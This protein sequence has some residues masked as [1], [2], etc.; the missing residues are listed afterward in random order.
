MVHPSPNALHLASSSSSSVSLGFL[1]TPIPPKLNLENRT[2]T[3][4]CLIHSRPL[5]QPNSGSPPIGHSSPIALHILDSG[6]GGGGG[7]VELATLVS[8]A[9]LLSLVS[10]LSLLSLLSLSLTEFSLESTGYPGGIGPSIELKSEPD[11]S[12]LVS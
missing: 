5:Q 11:N 9:P 4:P 7:G 12:S 2:R 6:G 8:L 10:L 3:R 1:Q